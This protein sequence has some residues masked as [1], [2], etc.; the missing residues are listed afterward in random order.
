MLMDS[1]VRAP[2]PFPLIGYLLRCDA[3]NILVDTGGIAPDGLKWAPYSRTAGEEMDTALA[4]VGISPEDVDIVLFTHLHWDHSSNNHFFTKARF[5]AQ[6]KEH[7]AL[8]SQ[9]D[10]KKGYEE[11]IA[12]GTDYELI[13]GD[14]ELFDGISVVLTPGHSRGS[15][16]VIVDTTDGKYALTGDL[17]PIY[18]NWMSRPRIL[19]GSLEDLSTMLDS[20]KKLESLD[21]VHILPGHDPAVFDQKIYP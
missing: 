15:Q 5:I 2:R 17:V 11:E 9:W 3:R 6:R 13:D 1:P 7:E 12:T 19:N 4:V 14:A 18:I 10:G 8:V 21:I 20:Y 16:C